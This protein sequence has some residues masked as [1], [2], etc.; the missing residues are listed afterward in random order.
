MGQE[1]ECQFLYNHVNFAH[2]KTVSDSNI[3]P[4]LSN[5]DQ[6]P[7]ISILPF[8]RDISQFLADIFSGKLTAIKLFKSI[9]LGCFCHIFFNL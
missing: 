7:E 3:N 8:V 4:G 1:F 2:Q 6:L 9:S 5:Q